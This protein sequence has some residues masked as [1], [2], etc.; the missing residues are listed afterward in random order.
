MKASFSFR[1]RVLVSIRS[2]IEVKPY[3]TIEKC[4]VIIFDIEKMQNIK[5]NHEDTVWLIFKHKTEGF[6]RSPRA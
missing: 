2:W 5:L 6:L 1:R 4:A 3:S